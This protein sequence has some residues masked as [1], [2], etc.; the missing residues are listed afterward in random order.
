MG[1]V[2]GESFWFLCPYF[3]DVFEGREALE[4]FEPPPIIMGVDEVVQVGVELLMAVVMIA[5]DGGVLDRPVHAF[6]LA[7]G[8]GMSDLGETM[9]DPVFSAA[10]VEHMGDVRG[11]RAVNVA[12]RKRELDAIVRQH[13]VDFVRN[14]G[15][16]RDQEG[17][18]CAPVRVAHKL[19]EDELAGAVDRHIQVQLAFCRPDLG[20][21]EMNVADGVGLECLLRLRVSSHLRKLADPVALQTTMP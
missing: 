17:G 20:D 7:I 3:A 19:D 14:R 8:P 6:H 15:D 1:W 10:H 9:L 5:L 16:Q 13:G 18:G 12:R 2:R 21:V 4:G 11:G